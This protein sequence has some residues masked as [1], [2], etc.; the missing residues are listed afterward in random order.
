MDNFILGFAA[1]IIFM[2]IF[3]SFWVILDD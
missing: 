3:I 2:V 1:S